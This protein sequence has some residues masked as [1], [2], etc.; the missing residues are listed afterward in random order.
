MYST[1][2][3]FPENVAKTFRDMFLKNLSQTFAEEAQGDVY[4]V[5][6]DN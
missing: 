2:L 4:L 6:K 3:E 1:D 5:V